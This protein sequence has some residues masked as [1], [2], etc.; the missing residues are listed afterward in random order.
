MRPARPPIPEETGRLN[1]KGRPSSLSQEPTGTSLA[2][3][4]AGY[5][6]S[7]ELQHACPRVGVRKRAVNKGLKR[8]RWAVVRHRWTNQVEPRTMGILQ[9]R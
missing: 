5:M 6:K 9:T 4:K 7:L 1:S 3:A 8:S 2:T